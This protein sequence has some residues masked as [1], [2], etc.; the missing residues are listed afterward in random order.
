MDSLK[1]LRK[2]LKAGKVYRRADLLQY[3]TAPDRHLAA[4]ISDGSLTKV[5]QG[6][7]YVPRATDFGVPPPDDKTLVKSFLKDNRFLILSP[8]MY[9][10]LGI[11]TTQLYN[12]RVVYNHKRHGLFEL[13]GLKFRFHR[14]QVFP[15][16]LTK[17]FLLV[18]LVSNLKSLAEDE[19]ALLQNVKRKAAEMNTGKLGKV[20]DRYGS[21]KARKFFAPLLNKPSSNG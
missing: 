5:S 19:N 17:E 21:I 8:N 2:H 3:T 16:I 7:Y 12:D 1:T 20:V 9:N 4:L 11:G 15:S 13:G 6:V 18:D 14:K 10:M